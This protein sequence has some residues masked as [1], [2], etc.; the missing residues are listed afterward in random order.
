MNR[1]LRSHGPVLTA[2]FDRSTPGRLL[3][4]LNAGQSLFTSDDGGETW[5][6]SV[7]GASPAERP[8]P[9]PTYALLQPAGFPR[10]ILA[11]TGGGLYRSSDAGGHWQAVQSEPGSQPVYALAGDRSGAAYQGGEG[12]LVRRSTDG[13]LGWQSL[14]PLPAGEA[15]LALAVSPSAD[16]LLAG[17]NGSGLFSS[18]D[19]GATWRRVDE[20]GETFVSAIVPQA[21]G[22]LPCNSGGDCVLARARSGLFATLDGGDTWR[23]VNG[24]WDGRLDAVTVA[25]AEPAWIV[26]TDRGQ[27]YRSNDGE[28]WE[29]W[30]EGLGRRGAVF[31]LARDPARPEHLVAGTENGFYRSLD[32]GLHWQQPIDGPGA[33]SAD[34]LA[35]GPGGLLFLGNLDGV[36]ASADEGATWERRSQGLPPVPIL[37]L[38]VAPSAPNVVYAGTSGAGLFRSEDGGRNWSVTGWTAPSVPGIVVHPQDP[39]R[40]YFRVAFERVYFSEDGGTTVQARWNGFTTFTEIMS[41]V[42]DDRQPDRLYAGGTDTLYRSTDGA[43][44][45]LPVGSELDG[46]TVFSLLPANAGQERLLAGATKGAYVSADEGMSWSRLGHGLEDITVTALA[47]HPLK[48]E[49][50][51]AGTRYKGVYRSGDSGRTWHPVGLGETSVNALFVSEDGHWLYAATPQGFFRAEAR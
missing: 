31:C 29:P 36:Y 3:A 20:V 11:A 26:A 6:S 40:I 21:A 45:W 25:G 41:L 38:A 28:R 1:G 35:R 37:S 48:R 15:V 49:R 22:Q 43:G 13:G 7:A 4:G 30:G 19:G 8:W 44:S 33:P 10:V 2:L 24:N 32:G 23:K 27:L 16:W 47:I 18:R 14:S 42:I 50:V 39:N 51:Y 34:A 46:Q 12:P 17:T 5:Q 9:P